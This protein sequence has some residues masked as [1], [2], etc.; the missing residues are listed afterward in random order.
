MNEIKIVTQYSLEEGV[1]ARYERRTLSS[2]VDWPLTE[3]T[4]PRKVSDFDLWVHRFPQFNKSY[5]LIHRHA[6]YE[7]CYIPGDRGAYLINDHQY[8]IEPGDVFI[9]NGNEFHQP[10]LDQCGKHGAF[11][12][13]FLP[14]LI[15]DFSSNSELLDYFLFSSHYRINRIRNNAILPELVKELAKTFHINPQPPLWQ[16]QCRGILTHILAIIASECDQQLNDIDAASPQ[17]PEIGKPGV[18]GLIRFREVIQ[19]ISNHL[20]RKIENAVLYRIA[21]LSRSQ[22]CRLFKES[23]GLSVSEYIQRERINRA[24][25]LLRSTPLSITEIAYAS[26]FNWP[27]FF[28]ETFRKHTAMNPTQYRMDEAGKK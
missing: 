28:N 21:G 3:N 12:I 22:F 17:N 9:V 4:V 11:V 2:D 7:I 15:K 1:V 23:F 27:G 26:G 24:K 8:T 14:R 20:H 19:Y 13:Y 6:E 18:K 5:R 25:C 10:I 16:T